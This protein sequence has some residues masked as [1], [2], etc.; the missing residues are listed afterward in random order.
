MATWRYDRIG[1]G[2]LSVRVY[3]FRPPLA[4]PVGKEVRR[5][6]REVARFFGLKLA[7]VRIE[8]SATV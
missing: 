6:A 4:R 5:Q 3:P 7:D 8:R 1:A 2:Q